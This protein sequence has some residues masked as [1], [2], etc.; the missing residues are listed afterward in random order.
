MPQ[1]VKIV[2][3]PELLKRIRAY[4][5]WDLVKDLGKR[6]GRSV[7]IDELK[8]Q[9]GLSTKEL[10]QVMWESLAGLTVAPKIAKGIQKAAQGIKAIDDLVTKAPK[11]TESGAGFKA[12]S[13]LPVRTGLEGP[14][15]FKTLRAW[16]QSPSEAAKLEKS[17]SLSKIVGV[18]GRMSEAKNRFLVNQ[19]SKFKAAQGGIK[20][21]SESSRRVGRALEAKLPVEQLNKKEVKLYD[22]LKDQFDYLYKQFGLA[23]ADSPESYN[24]LARVVSKDYK[25]TTKV[26]DLTAIRAQVYSYIES[27]RTA[28]LAGRKAS[29]LV[30]KE[31]KRYKAMEKGKNTL[32][33]QEWIAKL[34]PGDKEAYSILS[35]KVKH[36][37]PR[38]FDK[39]ELMARFEFDAKKIE[40]KLRTVTNPKK[41]I[42]LNKQLNSLRDNLNNLKG[43]RLIT[44]DALPE[45][46]KF[47]FLMSRKGAQG[48]SFDAAKAY[49]TY[50]FGFARK[51]YGDPALKVAKDLYNQVDPG[52]RDYASWFIKNWA[53]VGQQSSK[54]SATIASYQWI[55]ALGLNPRSAITNFTQRI[56]TIAEVGFPDSVKGYE[57]AWTPKGKEMFA[58]TGLA[59]EVPTVLME[60]QVASKTAEKIRRL[61]GFMFT[62]VELGN[63]KHAFLAGY[64]K[65]KRKGLDEQDAI[66]YGIDIVHKT[67]FRYGKIGMPRALSSS[68]G[69]LAF[70]FW[71]YPIKQ[72]EF[73]MNLA[74]EGPSGQYKLAKLLSMAE[75][76][77]MALEEF[78][79]IDLSNA[80][81]FG[82]NYGELI[83]VLGD[84]KEGEWKDAIRH[85]KLGFGGGGLLPTGLG[86]SATSAFDWAI[87]LKKGEG[88]EEALKAITPV[89]ITKAMKFGKGMQERVGDKVPMFTDDGER[90]LDLK[91]WEAVSEFVGPKTAASSKGFMDYAVRR[92]AKMAYKEWEEDILKRWVSGDKSGA[93]RIAHEQ[94]LDLPTDKQIEEWKWKNKVPADVRRRIDSKDSE[95]EMFIHRKEPGLGR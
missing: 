35:R 74:K 95:L 4:G 84:V 32:R 49:Q 37:L 22:F 20:E 53:G 64:S 28:L 93:A 73:M 52:W 48:Y 91:P 44:Y 89:M 42:K 66:Q 12:A 10:E 92:S 33:H 88:T 46:F 15:R 82:M 55:R 70:Q 6:L 61:A 58:R 80:L 1:R 21:G 65:A 45:A 26:R 9:P 16:F 40:D 67:Q 59:E 36:Y 3:D 31:L 50:L 63:R 79:G 85:T 13:E 90:T 17:G 76:G 18:L 11:T 7:D 8:K 81:G 60:G 24:K 69:R 68:T 30:G 29:S 5:V 78:L 47:R 94:G 54:L 86:P 14:G 72:M 39:D 77:N 19:V 43:G 23:A 75:G 2:K 34:S 38:I 87:G 62:R 25:P 71:S 57:M 56:N 27:R 83:K 51:F 41:R